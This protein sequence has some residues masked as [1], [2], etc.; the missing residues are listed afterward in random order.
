MLMEQWNSG[1]MEQW[2]T[3]LPD[4]PPM[5]VAVTHHSTMPVLQHSSPQATPEELS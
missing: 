2:N 5:A 3:P 1:M 4:M